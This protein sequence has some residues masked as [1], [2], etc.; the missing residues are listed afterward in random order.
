MFP[1]FC[2]GAQKLTI[3][4]DRGTNFIIRRVGGSRC[5]VCTGKGQCNAS[6]VLKDTGTASVD[7][8]CTKPEEE[9]S[10]EILRNIGNMCMLS[11]FI[12]IVADV[13]L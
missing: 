3:T 1:M 6:V 4:P 5:T 13:C 12:C 11:C 2:P 10:V 8:T 7:F 9:F